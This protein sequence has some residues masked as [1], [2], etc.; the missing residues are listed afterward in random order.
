MLV[1]VRTRRNVAAR[2]ELSGLMLSFNREK[3]ALKR[4]LLDGRAVVVQ[5]RTPLPKE[6]NRVCVHRI[7]LKFFSLF[8]VEVGQSQVIIGSACT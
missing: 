4:D 7:M 1:H 5:V 6:P 8:S 2:R 3:C